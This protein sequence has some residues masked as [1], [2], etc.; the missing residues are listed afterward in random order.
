MSRIAMR[1]PV[2]RCAGAIVAGAAALGMAG[3]AAAQQ[4][5]P[6]M[7][8]MEMPAMKRMAMPEDL[9]TRTRKTTEKGRY[10]AVLE[11]EARPVPIN[12]MHRWVL[13][14]HTRQ[15]KPVEDVPMAVSGGMPDHGHGLP[16]APRVTKYLGNGRYL[17]EGVRFNMTGW[18]QLVFAIGGAVPDSVTFNMVLK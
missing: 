1:F 15:G 18:W 4:G 14:V 2:L 12:R 8:G 10:L 9:D 11:P 3:A 16:T 5:M 13:S 6:S 7:G 17:V